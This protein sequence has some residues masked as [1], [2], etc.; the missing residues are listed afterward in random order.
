[1]TETKP[2]AQIHLVIGPVGAGKSTLVRQLCAEHR[3]IRFVLDEWMAALFGADERRA[4]GRMAWYVERTERCLALI[5]RLVEDA[6]A[7]QT[8][9]VL[10][11]GLIQREPRQSFYAKMDAGAYEHV[12]YV[13]DADR[14]VRRARVMRRN[15][16]RGETYSMQ[17]PLEF[18]ELASDL[19]EAPDA[20]ERADRNIRFI[21]T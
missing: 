3:A 12:V 8:S 20:L 13:V 14:E 2:P 7:A 16:E 15:E 10:E 19:W 1:M 21:T 5:W 17:V 6:L 11:L 4:E 18:F 9:V